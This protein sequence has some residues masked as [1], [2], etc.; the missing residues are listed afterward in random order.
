MDERQ[1]ID[2]EGVSLTLGAAAFLVGLSV[3]MVF[4]LADAIVQ[5]AADRIAPRKG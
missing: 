5:G 2:L 4:R 3:E 1:V